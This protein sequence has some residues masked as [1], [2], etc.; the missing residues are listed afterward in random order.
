MEIIG[1]AAGRVYFIQIFAYAN[2]PVN[3][4]YI[5]RTLYGSRRNSRAFPCPVPYE[6]RRFFFLLAD[7][8]VIFTLSPET[9]G[10]FETI[11]YNA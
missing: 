5:R 6:N 1:S 2:K 7:G 4:N 3:P 11:L 9:N 10:L 8:F